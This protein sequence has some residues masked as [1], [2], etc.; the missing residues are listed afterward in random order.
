[1]TAD[2]P[3]GA[4]LKPAIATRPR[5]WGI[6]LPKRDKD[7]REVT[8]SK[9]HP[10]YP[11]LTCPAGHVIGWEWNLIGDGFP[12]C[13]HDWENRRECGLR[14]WVCSIPRRERPG[15]PRFIVAEVDWREIAYMS[16]HYMDPDEVI[17]WLGLSWSP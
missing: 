4:D 13:T 3:K 15:S 8:D 16:E 5:R 11:E 17:A 2:P 12:R 10:V 9:G 7:G 14:L 6:L 1:M